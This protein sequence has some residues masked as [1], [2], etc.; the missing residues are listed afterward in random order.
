MLGGMRRTW[1]YTDVREN[2]DAIADRAMAFVSGISWLERGVTRLKQIGVGLIDVTQ[3]IEQL[4]YPTR[5]ERLEKDSIDPQGWPPM[6]P[7]QQ[8]PQELELLALAAQERQRNGNSMPLRM[9]PPGHGYG[10]QRMLDSE[11]SSAT[12][13]RTASEQPSDLPELTPDMLMSAS[14]LREVEAARAMS[15][16]Q[17][18]PPAPMREAQQVRVTTRV[19]P[20][21]AREEIELGEDMGDLDLDNLEGQAPAV[22]TN[23][24]MVLSSLFMGREAQEAQSVLGGEAYSSGYDI[25]FDAD[26]MLEGRTAPNETARFQIGRQTPPRAPF[27]G[28]MASGPSDGVVV[29]S[30]GQG[31]SWQAQQGQAPTAPAPRPVNVPINVARPRPAPSRP[32]PPPASAHK[33]SRL[34]RISRG[35]VVDDD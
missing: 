4:T 34:E 14:A 24:A 30:R 29:S 21:Q 11:V 26:S 5:W 27:S 10:L 8:T 23:D 20:V 7:R 25:E 31:G 32:V 13:G 22:T 18:L 15:A 9:A 16:P 19:A 33:V 3:S 6:S 17:Y 35:G 1:S 2:A 12:F 28:R